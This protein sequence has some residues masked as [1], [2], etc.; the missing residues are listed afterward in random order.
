M[1]SK[2]KSLLKLINQKIVE[3]GGK[4][5]ASYRVYSNCL[6]GARPH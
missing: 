3:G 4:K 6:G 5:S 2:L 1:E